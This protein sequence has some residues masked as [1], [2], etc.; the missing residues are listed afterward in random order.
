MCRYGVFQEY[1]LHQRTFGDASEAAIGAVGTVALAI[2]YFEVLIVIL[3]AQ[4]WPDKV[5]RLHLPT[6]G[7]LT[8]V[9]VDKD[10]DVV[11]LG[12]VLWKSCVG[13]FCYKSK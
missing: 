10:N 11:L 9:A 13:E 12:S 3:V 6:Q 5:C 2:E 4:Q 1:F 7:C 8:N